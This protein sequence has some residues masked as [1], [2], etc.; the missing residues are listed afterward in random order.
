MSKINIFSCYIIGESNI[1]IQCA[2]IILSK[3]HQLLGLISPS[4]KIKKWCS[5]NSIPYIE[6]IK[7]FEKCHL[8]ENF[9]YLFSIV[10][11][12]ILPKEILKLPSFYAINYHNSPLPKYAGL[13]AT[14]WAILN[15]ETEHA[16]SWH[17]MDEMIDAGDIL[18]QTSFPIDDQDT[19]LSLNLKC[20]EQ[21]IPSFRALVEELETN[22]TKLVKQDISQRSFYALKDKPSNLGF[23]S[24]DETAEDIDKLCR[25]LTFGN[26]TNQL[27]VPKVLIKGEIFV[28]TSHKKLN[29]SSIMKPGTIVN[30]SNECLQVTTATFD[31]VLLSLSDLNGVEYPI[32]QLMSSF[33]L[34]R[35]SELDKIEHEFIKKLGESPAKNP[36]IEKFWVN[37]FLKCIQEKSTF[38]SKLTPLEESKVSYP[39][40]KIV[41]KISKE[42][43]TKLEEFE[44][45]N[46]SLKNILLTASLIYLY[47]LNN[48]K[49]ISIQLFNTKLNAA[50]VNKL[51]SDFVPFTTDFDSEMTFKEALTYVANEYINLTENTTFSRDLF[52]RYPELHTL[53]EFEVSIRFSDSKEIKFCHSNNTKI[54]I[55]LSEDASWFHFHNQTN[56]KL[57]TESYAFLKQMNN[58][59][60]TLLEDII[61]HPNKK[62]FELSILGKREK[63]D[64]LITWNKTESDYDYKK[65]IHQ[66]IEERVAKTPHTIAAVFENRS[67]TF[68]ELNQKANQL[69]HYLRSQGVKPNH[70]IGISLNRSLEMVICILG[71]LKSGAAYLPLDPNYPDERISY[72]LI[73][74]QSNLLLVDK[75]S[76]KR[77]HD[78]YAGKIIEIHSVLNSEDQFLANLQVINKPSDLA[79]VIY[80]S[81]TTGKPKGVAIPHRAVC[82]HMFWMEKEYAFQERDVF[83]Q[84]TPF[85][86]DASV[87]EFFMPLLSGGKLVIAPNDAHASP[88]QM[89][90]LIKK[91]QVSILQLVPSMLKELVSLSAFETCTSL[92]HVFCGGEALLPETI[93][94]FFKRNCSNAKLH[95]LYGPT[96]ATIDTTTLN[97][98]ARDAEGDI[99]R[100]G[101]PIRNTKVY[102]LDVKMQPV[103]IGIIGELY[104]SGDG[105][106]LGY[107]NNP[108]FTNQKFITNPFSKNKEDRLYKTGDFVKW[109]ANG[110]LEYHG[111]GDSQIKIRGFRIEVNEIET[112][113]E[114]IP[115]IHQSVV[116]PERNL[117]DSISLSAYLVLAKDSQISSTDIRS[118]LKKYVPEYMIPSKFFVVD[119]LF[120]TPSGKIDRNNLPVPYEQLS[121]IN[122]NVAP[123]NDIEKSLQ[124]IWCS[125]L[126]IENIGIYNDFFELGGNS[127]SAMNIISLIQDQFSIVLSIRK[128]FNCPTIDALAREIENMSSTLSDSRSNLKPENNIVPLKTTGKKTPLFLVHPI[129]GSVFWY[130]LLRKYIDK[131]QPLYGIQDPGL[132]KNELIF[133]NLEEMASAYIE[134]IQTIQ[135]NGPYLIGGASFG[136]TV[137]IEIAKQLQDQGEIVLSIISLDGWA[138][139]PSLQNDEASF[140]NIMKEQNSR[141]LK[142]Y[143]ENN[144]SNSQYLLELQ[145][146]REKMLMQYEMPLIKTKFILFKAKSLNDMFQYDATYNWWE[147]YTSQPIELHAVPG[148]HESMFYEPH[149]K[150]LANKLND[151]LK[152][153]KSKSYQYSELNDSLI[154]YVELS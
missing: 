58:H 74:S 16:I 49:N 34:S 101:K 15:G 143:L 133:K 109:D 146:H 67:I 116:K 24:W 92:K 100:I 86:F 27:E 102:V 118:V 3:K 48:Y 32:E 70:L 152:I 107:L 44:N 98:S 149:V 33:K 43:F 93:N 96:E 136:S 150:V 125:V 40:N 50:D 111:R 108:E 124:T 12:E 122:D 59:F 130:T 126:K 85:S 141:L 42:L 84:K 6:S 13:Y 87:W 97:C 103:P 113:L 89:I 127:L 105:L 23:I 7:E 121:S 131:D 61:S 8:G 76:A 25:A 148:D 71:I 140:Q 37:K 134:S 62:L 28:V 17:V 147:N 60:L 153:E 69:A 73:D 99:S 31:I 41:T 9:D 30:I 66:H 64:L 14:S 137:A 77:Q 151:S 63:N 129:G 72:M 38:L 75:E 82:N 52:I 35:N 79:Y 145:W 139:Y 94:T 56:D 81:G 115:S 65:P 2:D 95:N 26:Y 54:N 68:E 36:K 138:F 46:H 106:A 114:K 53:G 83:L 11:N 120:I 10:N 45:G 78:G 88:I 112:H 123:K 128:L 117:D 132:D 29:S 55:S 154:D 119:K 18:K 51:L 21:A 22:T 90:R 57:H 135:P 19:A 142:K 80:T 5:I 20:Y 39:A 91:H 47:R 1:T 104:I 144:V 4:E 110:I